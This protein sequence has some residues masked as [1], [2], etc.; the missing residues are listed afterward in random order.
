MRWL[1]TVLIALAAGFAG[2][3]L[4]D[5]SGLGDRAT[6]A[7]LLAHPEVLPEAMQVLQQRE[8]VVELLVYRCRGQQTDDAAHWEGVWHSGWALSSAP[9]R[10]FRR[11]DGTDAPSRNGKSPTPRF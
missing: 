2:S 1:F 8:P 4:W 10:A 3:A 5:F 11:G 6:R 7:Y 9:A